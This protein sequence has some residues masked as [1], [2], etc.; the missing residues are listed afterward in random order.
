MTGQPA[1]GSNPWITFD[2]T[3]LAVTEGGL[4]SSL[5]IEATRAW[6]VAAQFEFAGML[7]PWIVSLGAPWNFR[8]L[9]ESMGPGPDR[10][11]GTLPGVTVL[12][13]TAYGSP[14]TTIN[15]AAGTL[16]IGVYKLVGTVT[17]TGT[18]PPAIAGYFEG[19]IVQIV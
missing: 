9:A 19:P 14:A 11:L 2:V 7:A 10:V 3:G 5:V 18:P 4:P 6:E 8:L 12:G 1:P 16:P 15:V 13:T 17:V